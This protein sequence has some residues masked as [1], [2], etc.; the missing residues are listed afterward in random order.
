VISGFC[1]EANKNCAVMGH[2]TDSSGHIPEERSYQQILLLSKNMQIYWRI[3]KSLKLVLVLGQQNT[4]H[5]FPSLCL[6]SK[7]T[8]AIVGSS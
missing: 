6:I 4:V 7:R 2:Y 8:T 1:R 3:R 5:V